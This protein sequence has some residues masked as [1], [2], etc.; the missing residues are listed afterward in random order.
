MTK[1]CPLL[2]W[3]WKAFQCLAVLHWWRRFS[4]N[5]E[6]CKISLKADVPLSLI[7]TSNLSRVPRV[8]PCRF[9][10]AGVNFY[11]FNAKNWRFSVKILFSKNFAR[12]KKMTNIRYAQSRQSSIENPGEWP[13][14]CALLRFE[15][16]TD[17]EPVKLYEARFPCLQYLAFLQISN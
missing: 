1:L 16:I 2:S 10:L 13:H 14:V 9:F 6:Y 3:I 11:R 17:G 15:S 7:H 12:V 4:T 5:E 8:Y